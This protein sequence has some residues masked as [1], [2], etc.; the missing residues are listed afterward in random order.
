MKIRNIL[1]LAILLTGAVISAFSQP[2][3]RFNASESPVYA[4][5]GAD[6]EETD[7]TGTTPR[8]KSRKKY[9]YKENKSP[10]IAAGL[11]LILPGAGEFYGRD[12]L[13]SGIFFGI[14]VTMLSMWYY[15]E[16]DGDDKKD[17]Y[18]DYADAHFDEKLYYGGLMAMS[19]NF[20]PYLEYSSWINAPDVY[21]Y[22]YFSDRDNWEYDLNDSLAVYDMLRL[23]FS[24]PW[25]STSSPVQ[26]G[27]T[28]AQFTHNLPESK[29][30]QYYEM[31]GKYHQ[32]ACGWTDFTGYVY[33][34]DGTVQTEEITVLDSLGKPVAVTIPKFEDRAIDYSEE[35]DDSAGFVNTYENLRDETNKAYETGSNFLMVTLLNH[36][37]SAFD[38]SYVIKSKFQID[39][40]V[41]IENN[42]KSDPIGLD[43]YKITYS[44]AW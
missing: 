27:G 26:L 41:R 42:D 22:D 10:M 35:G 20:L 4:Q 23:S 38:A 19:Q 14:E 24:D 25:N 16:S 40:Q 5:N 11:S 33:N 32:F 21:N 28:A 8:I 39:T 44:I 7:V 1:I 2:G 3:F 29:T 30:Q 13:R 31:V 18:R 17:K 6:N 34:E 9:E 15:F 37:A 12:Y 43:N 36:V